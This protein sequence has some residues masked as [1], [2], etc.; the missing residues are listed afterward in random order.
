MNI[1]KE[2][3]FQLGI[4]IGSGA[5]KKAPIR[6]NAEMASWYIDSHR[7]AYANGISRGKLENLVTNEYPHI[8]EA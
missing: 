6:N 3:W 4:K 8:M 5:L 7:Q 2:Y 1:D